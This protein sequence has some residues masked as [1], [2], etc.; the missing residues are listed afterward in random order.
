MDLMYL[1]APK[2]VGGFVMRLALLTGVV[3]AANFV[4]AHSFGDHHSHHASYYIGHAL[5]VGTPLIG[6]F[7][8][9]TVYQVRLQRKLYRLA[10]EDGLTGLNNRRAFFTQTDTARKSCKTGVLLMLDADFFKPINDKYGHDAG[11]ACLRSIAHT[12]RRTVRQDDIVGRIGGEEFAIYL[13]NTTTAQAQAIGERLTKPIAF[14]TACDAH[15]TV[16]LSIGATVSTPPL[17]SLDRLF[18]EADKALYKAKQSGRARMMFWR[19]EL[20]GGTIQADH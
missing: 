14:R 4:Y 17:Q 2:G 6:F 9:V 7:L 10:R 11:D 3:I 18:I 12:L 1:F 16:T 5:F 19:Q 15:L 8:A 20:D 13:Q